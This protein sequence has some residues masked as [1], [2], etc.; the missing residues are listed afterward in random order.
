MLA[1]LL[2]IMGCAES[3]EAAA[4]PPFND[5]TILGSARVG[6]YL[7][8]ADRRALNLNNWMAANDELL[9]HDWRVGGEN[10]CIIKPITAYWWPVRVVGARHR[11]GRRE[12]KVSYAG[13][14]SE[15]DEW[16]STE[17]KL[18]HRHEADEWEAGGVPPLGTQVEATMTQAGGAHFWIGGAV[19]GAAADGRALI[20][21][22]VYNEGP[23]PE[24]SFAAN[25]N[26]R[27]PIHQ[28]LAPLH[29]VRLRADAPAGAAPGVPA[30]RR[31]STPPMQTPTIV[32]VKGAGYR[33]ANGAYTRDGEY[34]GAPLFKNGQLWLLRYRMPRGTHYW[35]IADK[36]RLDVDAGDLYR[37]RSASL[38][39]PAAG[40]DLA[41][42]GHAPAPLLAFAFGEV[43]TAVPVGFS[44]AEAGLA[45]L[46]LVAAVAAGS[47][48]TTT[49]STTT[50]AAAGF[51]VP[52]TQVGPTAALPAQLPSLAELAAE[53]RR[54]LRVDGPNLVAVV[55]A[56]CL[57]LGLEDIGHMTVAEKASRCW[58]LLHGTAVPGP[59]I[60]LGT[61]VEEV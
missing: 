18:R 5:G 55:D 33:V 15:W 14:S 58:A 37:V 9:G 60:A 25:P 56:A 59:R 6:D 45:P 51:A 48:T 20:E 54:E 10:D 4:A 24:G 43:A 2:T 32:F 17:H 27:G 57:E 1:F 40:W 52:A 39:P 12:I 23:L 46:P 8:A 3:V 41:V 35:Y 22:D 42:D 13:Y 53:F 36:D 38:L 29:L 30:L 61:R 44:S 16:V 47:A 7:E 11:G 34:G 49:T 31:Q 21:L 50:T 28:I 19:Q 26:G